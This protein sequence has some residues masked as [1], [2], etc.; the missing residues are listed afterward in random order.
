MWKT[1]FDFLFRIIY[2]L[3]LSNLLSKEEMKLILDN[4]PCKKK[5]SHLEI[6]HSEDGGYCMIEECL[7]PI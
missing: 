2:L 7:C 1:L 4:K 3:E 6:F 5:C